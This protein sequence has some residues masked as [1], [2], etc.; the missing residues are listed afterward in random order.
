MFVPA[1]W[2]PA[3][4]PSWVRTNSINGNRNKERSVATKTSGKNVFQAWKTKIL[5]LF[6]VQVVSTWISGS[7]SPQPQ[8]FFAH[9]S[10]ILLSSAADWRRMCREA[11]T[12]RVS[13]WLHRH[14][15]AISLQLEEKVL[16]QVLGLVYPWCIGLLVDHAF[17]PVNSGPISAYQI[18]CLL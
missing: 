4:S 15:G 11:S 3:L 5:V 6:H 14:P 8:F 13:R 9:A 1:W 18:S 17:H 2:L 7:E 12:S 16:V 10:Q